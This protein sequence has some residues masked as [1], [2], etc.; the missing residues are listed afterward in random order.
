MLLI[1]YFGTAH[2][3]TTPSATASS[4]CPPTLA[5]NRKKLSQKQNEIIHELYLL[6]IFNLL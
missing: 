4:S 3:H 2:T 1:Q 5:D 6:F